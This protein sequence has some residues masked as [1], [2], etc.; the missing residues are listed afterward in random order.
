[1]NMPDWI[2]TFPGSVMV[3]DREHRLLWMNDKAAEGYADQGGRDL[4]GKDM[5]SCHTE[6][7]REIIERLLRTG[8]PNAYTIEKNG[9]KKFI[10]Q[11]AWT[12]ESGRIAGLVEL[13]LAIP[14]DMPHFVRS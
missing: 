3:S 7:S 5:M 8:E 11:V 13:S 4:I 12:D 9:K 2:T 14:F 6:R 1:M 10:Y